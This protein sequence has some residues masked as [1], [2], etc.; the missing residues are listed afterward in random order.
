M[1]YNSSAR[2]VLYVGMLAIVGNTLRLALHDVG[3]ALPPATFVGA[4][5]VGLLASLA[6]HWLNEPRIAL[7]VPGVIMMVP[8][9]YA[10]ETLVQCDQGEILAALQ[11]AILVVFVVGAMAMG[12]AVARF[13]SQPE[14]LRE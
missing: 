4:L 12:L 13:I 5:V 1:L 6:R 3:L 9:L 11:S 8:G 2:T 14:W 7:T 10:F